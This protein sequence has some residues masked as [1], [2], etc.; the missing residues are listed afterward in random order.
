MKVIGDVYFLDT[1]G[2]K[3]SNCQRRKI[4]QNAMGPTTMATH[5]RGFASLTKTL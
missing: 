1:V 2:K 3:E 5:P 4:V